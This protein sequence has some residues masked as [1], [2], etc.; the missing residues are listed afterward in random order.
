MTNSVM[1]NKIAD[2]TRALI[3]AAFARI[4]KDGRY[5][6]DVIEA[7]RLTA[8]IAK[9]HPLDVWLVLGTDGMDRLSRP[10]AVIN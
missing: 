2:E 7:A 5:E 3:E 6:V 10:P 9:V 4:C 8:S 1:G